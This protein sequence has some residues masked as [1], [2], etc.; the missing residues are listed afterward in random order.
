[1]ERL[2]AARAGRTTL[3]CTTSPLVLSRAEHVIFV[4]DGKVTAE[5]THG[6]LLDGEPRYRATVSREED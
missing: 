2:R 5:G 6:E 1:A 3:A 4:E